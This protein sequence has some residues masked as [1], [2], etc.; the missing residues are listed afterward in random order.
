MSDLASWFDAGDGEFCRMAA[1]GWTVAV[2]VPQD[3]A[4]LLYSTKP[5][6]ILNLLGNRADALPCGLIGGYGLPGDSDWQAIANIAS[7]RP[8]RL[9]GDADPVDL[10]IFAELRKRIVASYLGLSDQMLARCEA[11]LK[12]AVLIPLS[13][14]ESAAISQFDSLI[15]DWRTLVG[16]EIAALLAQGRKL[17]LEGIVSC[18]CNDSD[19]AFAAVTE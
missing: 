7:G 1:G 5:Q 9:V 14:N 19:Q 3:A 17:E 4:F 13:Q 15:P 18:L 10:L 11:E 6:S 16:P 12:D 2:A 8:I